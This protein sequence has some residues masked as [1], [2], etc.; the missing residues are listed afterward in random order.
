MAICKSCNKGQLV[1]LSEAYCDYLKKNPKEIDYSWFGRLFIPK[2]KGDPVF[3]RLKPPR[4]I[5]FTDWFAPFIFLVLVLSYWA[6]KAV[7]TLPILL[8]GGLYVGL[9]TSMLAYFVIFPKRQKRK[10]Q[11]WFDSLACKICYS[12]VTN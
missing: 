8:T 6:E 2:A 5:Y 9:I 11:A 12:I 4:M 3:D 10:I 7:T 1:P